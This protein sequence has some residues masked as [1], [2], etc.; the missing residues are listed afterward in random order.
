VAADHPAFPGHFPGNP[1]VPGV[2]LLDAAIHAIAHLS[3]HQTDRCTLS[4][5]KFLSVLLPGEPLALQ[6]EAGVTSGFRFSLLSNSRLIAKGNIDFMA[7]DEQ[8]HAQ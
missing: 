7:P 3:H 1:I 8:T 6:F 4:S 2:V 5:V